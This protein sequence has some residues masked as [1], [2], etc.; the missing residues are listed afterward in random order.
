M[1][2]DVVL[3]DVM[4]PVMDG[5]EAL[6]A[7]R[8]QEAQTGRHLPIIMATSHDEPGEALRYEKAGA[9]GYL[10]KPLDLDGLRAEIE[11]VLRRT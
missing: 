2:V 6:A 11:R 1:Q 9:D 5:L 10:C 3:M 8:A 7:I 4:M